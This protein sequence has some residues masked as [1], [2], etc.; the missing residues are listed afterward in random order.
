MIV[1]CK[2]KRMI[3]WRFFLMSW[4]FSTVIW[5]LWH[6][7]ITHSI[8]KWPWGHM[9]S[10]FSFSFSFSFSFF[11][12]FFFSFFSFFFSRSLLL[13]LIL[14]PTYSCNHITGNSLILSLVVCY[15]FLLNLFCWNKF[16]KLTP[17]G[18]RDNVVLAPVH[19]GFVGGDAA[20]VLPAVIHWIGQAVTLILKGNWPESKTGLGRGEDG[21]G[22]WTCS[23][24]G[25]MAYCHSPVASNS[26]STARGC[27]AFWART[28]WL[29]GTCERK[30]NWMDEGYFDHANKKKTYCQM[31]NWKDRD[32][33]QSS[34]SVGFLIKKTH[35]RKRCPYSFS[36]PSPSHIRTCND[37]GR[38]I[39]DNLSC[40]SRDRN[41]QK[42]ITRRLN[43]FFRSPV[44]GDGPS[45]DPTRNSNVVLE[46]GRSGDG[47]GQCVA[48][49]VDGID[50]DR[51][52][53]T[54]LNSQVRRCKFFFKRDNDWPDARVVETE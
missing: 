37:V 44:D 5:R 23:V 54:F 15:A 51:N 40:T 3:I 32:V 24:L 35:F 21:S 1:G 10:F 25:S 14:L 27:C 19:D 42:P 20:N 36:S 49:R 8:A 50:M 43:R 16:F 45:N 28:F 9:N 6:T 4:R 34:H 30:K 33:Q 17:R 11:S 46:R 22:R 52:E 31:Q 29:L 18:V 7:S 39:E 53:V 2:K 12:Y 13:S 41:S 26:R 38:Q 47:R 48:E